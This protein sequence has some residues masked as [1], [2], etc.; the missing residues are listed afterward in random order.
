MIPSAQSDILLIKQ[1]VSE[2]DLYNQ[3][4]EEASELAHAANK[5]VRVLRGTNPTPVDKKK[6]MDSVIEEYTD[7][8]SVAS[9]ILELRPDWL[10]GDYKLYRWRRRLEEQDNSHLKQ[11]S[12]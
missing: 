4:A 1:R 5:M 12:I 2:E 11:A 8:V 6:A 7:L 9:N 10:I 3:R